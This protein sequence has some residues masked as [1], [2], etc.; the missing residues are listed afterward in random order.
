MKE[1]KASVIIPVYNT[2]SDDLARSVGSALQQS[3]ANIEVVVV[4][5]GSEE[6]VALDCDKYLQVDPRVKVIHQ[7]NRGLSAAR[8]AGFCA[9]SGDWVMFLDSDDWIERDSV[10]KMLKSGE[11]NA[12]QLVMS[13][14]VKDYGTRSEIFALD[15]NHEMV[16]GRSD[17]ERLM[18]GLFD[19]DS[20]YHDIHGKLFLRS[21]LEENG[22]YHDDDVRMGS[23]S[24]LFNLRAF[25]WLQKVTYVPI[26]TYHYTFNEGSISTHYSENYYN[27]LLLSY[28][29]IKTLIENLDC[30]SELRVQ[31]H[32]ALRGHLPNVVASMAVGCLFAPDS[33]VPYREA[34]FK[35]SVFQRELL[36]VAEPEGF[37]YGGCS[38]SRALVNRLIAIGMYWPIRAIASIR[39][40]QKGGKACEGHGGE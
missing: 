7:Q 16:F 12:C 22:V 3:F 34:C 8:N 9:A 19:W 25:R 5:D 37:D 35:V 31:L 1:P 20:R 13:A 27:G 36:A 15:Y 39:A 21:F 11:G 26:V 2:A 23:E 24:L 18:V 33:K 30:A 32:D 40:L 6:H 10:E 38:R 29:R 17:C 28:Q 4:D 14:W